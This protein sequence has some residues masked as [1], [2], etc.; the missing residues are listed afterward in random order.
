MDN[1]KYI[2]YKWFH[3]KLFHLL[4]TKIT[5]AKIHLYTCKKKCIV[6]ISLKNIFKYL[7][8]EIIIYNYTDRKKCSLENMQKIFIKS[9]KN[10][11]FSFSSF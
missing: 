1:Q 6:K 2:I 8:I 10:I 9:Q 11:Y 3:P 4:T 5:K 7:N